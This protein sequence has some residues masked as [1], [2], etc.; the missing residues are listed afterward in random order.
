[1]DSTNTGIEL[2]LYLLARTNT[3]K[4]TALII[5]GLLSRFESIKKAAFN[6]L[7]TLAERKELKGYLERNRK[8]HDP[9]VA[10]MADHISQPGY[11]YPAVKALGFIGT[12]ESLSVIID[13]IDRQALTGNPLRPAFSKAITDV[14]RDMEF[15]HFLSRGSALT[16]YF[17]E[18]EYIADTTIKLRD[19]IFQHK[20]AGYEEILSKLKQIDPD[21][22]KGWSGIIF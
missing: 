11:V 14:A 15:R 1:C 8:F 17:S 12:E 22:G 21:R 3:D 2:I 19:H 20:D 16:K 4:G 18:H 6:A 9:L 7:A 5:E 13:E 10:A